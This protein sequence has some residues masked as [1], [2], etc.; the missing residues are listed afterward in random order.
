MHSRQTKAENYNVNTNIQ[1][2]VTLEAFNFY[3]IYHIY[4]NTNTL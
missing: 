3:F 4:Y 1:N 2:H